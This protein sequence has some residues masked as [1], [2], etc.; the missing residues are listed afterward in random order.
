MRW[1]YERWPWRKRF[2]FL[3][4]CVGGECVWCAWFWRRFAGDCYEVSFTDPTQPTEG[5]SK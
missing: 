4:V 1:A 5:A 2:A 3:P